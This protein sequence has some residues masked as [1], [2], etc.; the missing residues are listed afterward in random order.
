MQL[1]RAG[2]IIPPSPSRKETHMTD[3]MIILMSIV[4]VAIIVDWIWLRVDK[5]GTVIR[6]RKDRNN[7]PH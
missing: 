1:R 4:Q 2:G 3:G 6:S 5:L 7:G